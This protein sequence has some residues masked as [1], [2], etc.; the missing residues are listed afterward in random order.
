MSTTP[1]EVARQFIAALAANDEA[2]CLNVLHPD[3]GLRVWA[4]N[5]SESHRPRARVLRRLMDERAAWPDAILETFRLL[6]DGAR[7]AVEFRI[8]ATEQGRL[9]EHNRSVVLE[10]DGEQVKTIDLTCAAPMPSA[11]RRGWIAPATLSEADLHRVFEGYHYSGDNRLLIWPGVSVRETPDF[12]QVESDDPHPGSNRLFSARWSADEADARIEQVIA[13]FRARNCG[14]C[15]HVGPY[16]TPSDLRVRL[17]QHGCALA[18]D[19]ALMARV[20][21]DDLSDI[22]VNPDV[23]VVAL[24]GADD[25]AIEA[26]LRITAVAFRWTHEQ[27]DKRRPGW[28]E[29]VKNPTLRREE[30]VYLARLRGQPVAEAHLAWR[31]GTAY[32]AGAATLPEARGQRLY[33]TLLRRR[34][35]HAR[36]QGYQ[37]AAINAEPMSRRIVSRYGF[38]TYGM[39]YLYGWMPVMDLNVIRTLVQND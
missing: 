27:L 11:R 21:L 7:V 19:Q 1:A 18:G 34:L 8:Q 31:V 15:W 28:V 16:D 5:G 2:A 26:T 32:L 14:F 3:V 39:Y 20:G 13:H 29:V 37:I 30:T 17:E 38:Q 23:E 4:W 9:M 10:V 36:A 25:E 33:S 12:A 6:A 24:D 22:P 35:E